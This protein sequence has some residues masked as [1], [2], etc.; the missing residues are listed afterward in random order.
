MW[1]LVP[2]SVVLVLGGFKGQTSGQSPSQKGSTWTLGVDMAW[3]DLAGRSLSTPLHPKKHHE[4][5]P[6]MFDSQKLAGELSDKHP[7]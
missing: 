1:F 2:D 6:D 4:S 7:K 5:K 3:V